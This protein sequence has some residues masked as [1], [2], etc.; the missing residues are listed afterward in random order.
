MQFLFAF[1]LSPAFTS[2]F[3]DLGTVQRITYV[4]ALLL[5][6]LAAALFTASAALTAPSSSRASSPASCRSPRAWPPSALCVLVFAFSGSVL[7]VAGVTTGRTGGAAAGAA[8]FLVCVGLWGCSRGWCGGR[9]CVRRRTAPEGP[10]RRKRP[11]AT[12]GSPHRCGTPSVSR[13]GS[14]GRRRTGRRRHGTGDGCGLRRGARRGAGVMAAGV[15]RMWVARAG[16]RGGH[17]LDMPFGSCSG[18][19]GLLPRVN[20]VPAVCA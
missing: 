15:A 17:P 2:R 5:A 4:V 6:V 14:E 9:G 8:A 11:G 3:E 12:S 16:V 1:L 20:R 10:P 19:A 7:L 13:Q 18:P